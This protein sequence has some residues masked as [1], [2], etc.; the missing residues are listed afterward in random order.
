METTKEKT[1]VAEEVRPEVKK[2]DFLHCPGCGA[3]LL[4]DERNSTSVAYCRK[5]IW[6]NA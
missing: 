6:R 1:K 4:E 2:L 3:E 5:C